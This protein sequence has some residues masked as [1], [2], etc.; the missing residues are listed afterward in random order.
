MTQNLQYA[1]GMSGIEGVFRLS[2][3]NVLKTLKTGRETLLTLLEAFGNFIYSSNRQQNS[4]NKNRQLIFLVY[5][6]LLDWTGNDTGIIASFYGG[7]QT[8][9]KASTSL[10]SNSDTTDSSQF[11]SK[12][13]RR[14][15]ERKMTLRLYE[16]RLIENANLLKS[17]EQGLMQLVNNFETSLTFLC[18]LK[19]KR[20]YK[21]NLIRLHELAKIHLD[22]SLTLHNDNNKTKVNQHAVYTLHDRYA[23]YSVYTQHRDTVF[24]SIKS[25]CDNLKKLVEKYSGSIDY[26][27]S[28]VNFDQSKDPLTQLVQ[29]VALFSNEN[30][31]IMQLLT[32]KSG[33]LDQAPYLVTVDFF[34][35]ISQLNLTNQCENLYK[36][37]DQIK[38]VQKNLLVSLYNLIRTKSTLFNWLPADYFSRSSLTKCIQW[39]DMIREAFEENNLKN[40]SKIIQSVQKVYQQYK[41][42]FNP[43][44]RLK[45]QKSLPREPSLPHL[46]SESKYIAFKYEQDETIKKIELISLRKSSIEAQNEYLMSES[47]SLEQSLLLKHD[48]CELEM[49]NF[50][51]KELSSVQ[52]AYDL[53]DLQI[54]DA[55]GFVSLQFLNE[56][57]QKWMLME[58]ASLEAKE[59]LISL[60][61]IEGD[62]FLEEMYSLIANCNHLTRL[63]QKLFAKFNLIKDLDCYSGMPFSKFLES[64]D[65]LTSLLTNLKK[66]LFSFQINLSEKLIKMAFSNSN[67]LQYII[68]QFKQ[69]NTDQFFEYI[70]RENFSIENFANVSYIKIQDFSMLF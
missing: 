43:L 57:L 17:N 9:V 8:S 35:S 59:Q 15:I 6:P 30:N 55:F 45:S 21:E 34:Q 19:Q 54:F 16:I 65:T 24:K 27:K 10:V 3:E 12:Q 5:D 61:S 62:W 70:S 36:E 51:D 23:K 47:L 49:F 29:S 53:V 58:N 39:M 11:K 46:V 18:D 32:D 7:G 60:T 33:R 14:F 56:N 66:L 20:E 44:F 2:C 13:D 42:D 4:L 26:V 22:E 1:L 25:L 31:T 68:E 28:L 41:S 37:L 67:E 69:I 52:S 64:C 38:T 50:I 48:E 63:I 40:N